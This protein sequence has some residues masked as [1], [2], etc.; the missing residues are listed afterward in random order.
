M[1]GNGVT[2]IT[3][4]APLESAMRSTLT[5][6]ILGVAFAASLAVTAGACGDDDDELINDEQQQDIN[7]G[8]ED[9]EQEVEEGG[10][11][12]EQQIDEGAEEGE[13]G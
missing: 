12:V 5:R 11:E 10:D 6:R 8:G 9:L 2:G 1:L 7:E 4:V 13:D 3:H